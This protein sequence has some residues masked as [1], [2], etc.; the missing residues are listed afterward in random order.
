MVAQGA[1]L[2]DEM[3]ACLCRVLDLGVETP[4]GKMARRY[5]HDRLW[6]R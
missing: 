2:P 5:L 4:I 3:Q 1:G 6:P